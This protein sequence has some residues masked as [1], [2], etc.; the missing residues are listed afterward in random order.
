MVPCNNIRCVKHGH[1]LLTQ[2]RATAQANSKK[3]VDSFSGNPNLQGLGGTA[4]MMATLGCL[5]GG[6]RRTWCDVARHL[7]NGSR[8]L[9]SC[10]PVDSACTT[11]RVTPE[12]VKCPNGCQ[13]QQE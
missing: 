9:S 3:M 4:L 7:P 13:T 8:R 10:R 5:A 6:I 12:A 11:A 2:V 1:A